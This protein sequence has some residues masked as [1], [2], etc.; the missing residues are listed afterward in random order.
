MAIERVV[1]DMML[2][3]WEEVLWPFLDAWDS[4]RLRTTGA[5]WNVPRRHR[6]CGELFFFVL[7]QEPIVLR[8]LVRMGPSIQPYGEHLLLLV[9]KKPACVPDS[10]AFN[11]FV[12]DGFPRRRRTIR[13][14][15]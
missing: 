6:P 15:T 11:S 14:T 5:E 1:S 13:Q 7:K 12:G 8:E 3:L 4:V 2:P 9:Q 10:K